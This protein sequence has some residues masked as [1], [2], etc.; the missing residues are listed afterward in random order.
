MKD[1]NSGLACV[2][3][4]VLFRLGRGAEL[5]ALLTMVVY[6]LARVR[7]RLAG[8]NWGGRHDP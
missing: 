7:G 8:K 4:R 5:D 6:F 2:R 1:V 3:A